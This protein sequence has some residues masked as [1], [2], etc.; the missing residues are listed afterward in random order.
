MRVSRTQIVKGVTDYIQNDV[1]PKMDNEFKLNVVFEYSQEEET[2]SMIMKY[3][4]EHFDIRNTPNIIS[5][6]IAENASESID[7][8]ECNEGDFTNLVTV[9]IK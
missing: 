6:A 2:L 1:L 5:Y 3:D 9:K 8:T 7:Y 4:G